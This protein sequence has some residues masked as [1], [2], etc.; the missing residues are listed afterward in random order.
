M[1]L[2]LACVKLT[3]IEPLAAP[4]LE[5]VAEVVEIVTVEVTD[6]ATLYSRIAADGADGEAWMALA[7]WHFQEGKIDVAE[8]CASRAAALGVTDPSLDND[9]GVAALEAGD[10]PRAL[11]SFRDALEADPGHVDANLNIAALALRAAD[12][13]EARS[14]FSVVLRQDP[15]HEE[16]MIGLGAALAGL[17]EIDAAI[18]EI[19]GYLVAA[20]APDPDAY[21]LRDSLVLARD[22]EVQALVVKRMAEKQAEAD[23]SFLAGYLEGLEGCD[24]LI[25]DHFREVVAKGDPAELASTVAYVNEDPDGLRSMICP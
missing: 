1:L 25:L 8:I 22:A 16:A 11:R 12:F 18:A 9:R 7:R 3:V 21:R 5:E 20:H 23:A 24:P 15:T 14:R 2:L 10:T 19:D 13:D 6:P 4:H 17:G